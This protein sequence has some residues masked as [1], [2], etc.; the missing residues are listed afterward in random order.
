MD[1]LPPKTQRTLSSSSK[2]PAPWPQAF[3]SGGISCKK[4]LRQAV[5]DTWQSLIFILLEDF[6]FGV[7]L[8][9]DNPK[10]FTMFHQFE[11]ETNPWQTATLLA[12]FSS[13]RRRRKP[14][15]SGSPWRVTD[16][17]PAM[18]FAYLEP[19]WTWDVQMHLFVTPCSL[20]YYD[21]LYLKLCTAFKIQNYP[22]PMSMSW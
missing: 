6:L 12:C 21:A 5:H 19:G 15:H 2:L 17:L 20:K 8:S 3:T 18:V 14:N 1:C 13:R 22:Q 10:G 11:R 16:W 4:K 9:E 7:Y